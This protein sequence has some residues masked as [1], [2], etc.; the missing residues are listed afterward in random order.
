M[1][2]VADNVSGLQ[3]YYTEKAANFTATPASAFSGLASLATPTPRVTF[4]AAGALRLDFGFEHAAWFEFT[5]TDLADGATD[6]MAAISE[7]NEPWQVR[8]KLAPL[9]PYADGVYRLQTNPQLY[10]GVRFAWIFFE[11]KPDSKRKRE[12]LAPWTLSGLRLVSQSTRE[13]VDSVPALGCL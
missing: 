5:S 13:L 8:A 11:R 6:V 7:Y 2:F 1:P 3:V 9:T 10:E 4:N 12:P